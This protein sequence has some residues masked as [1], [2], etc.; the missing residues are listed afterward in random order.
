M[1]TPSL[2]LYSIWIAVDKDNN[3]HQVSESMKIGAYEMNY[4]LYLNCGIKTSLSTIK[5]GHCKLRPTRYMYSESLAY[6]LAYLNWV[7]NCP[8][9]QK[10]AFFSQESDTWR[11]PKE[12]PIVDSWLTVSRNPVQS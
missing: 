10:A 3:Q 11:F 9:D 8:K 2:K 7:I 1:K 6:H 12:N 5:K 4:H